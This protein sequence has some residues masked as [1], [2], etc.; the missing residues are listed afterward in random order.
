MQRNSMNQDNDRIGSNGYR[1]MNQGYDRDVHHDDRPR[2][3]RDPNYDDRGSL[4]ANNERHLHDEHER[5]RWGSDYEGQRGHRYQ[6]GMI[7]DSDRN[8]RRE[9]HWQY[10]DARDDHRMH[11]E[12]YPRFQDRDSR[13][14]F[15][16]TGEGRSHT[17]EDD[18]YRMDRDDRGR[19][20][21]DDT[22]R[23]GHP[24]YGYDNRGYDNHRHFDNRGH[25]NHRSHD[26]L[27]GHRGHDNRGYDNRGY[28]N[29]GYDNN[30]G[31]DGRGD[32]RGYDNHRNF[33][34]H[35]NVD[36]HDNRDYGRG[37]YGRDDRR[38]DEQHGHG[39]SVSNDRHVRDDHDRRWTGG[40]YEEDRRGR[41]RGR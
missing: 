13:G 9:A 21:S 37:G 19:F 40:G 28:D 38:F 39:G 26:N 41:G 4:G 12:E 35:R 32:N 36:N 1:Q 27:S 24:G 5:G 33:D 6:G 17:R 30:R 14:R 10:R 20:A 22:R 7:D 31:N 23:Y 29:R 15:N 18:R 16:D 25:D 11:H 34:N 3:Y 8:R 2:S